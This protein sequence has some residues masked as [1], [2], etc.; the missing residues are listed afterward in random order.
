[1]KRKVIKQGNNT[2][3]ITL[4]KKWTSSIGLKDGDELDIIE[5]GKELSVLFGGDKEGSRAKIDLRGLKSLR[6]M[7]WA[8]SSIHKIG[9]DEIEVIYD[10]PKVLRMIQEEVKSIYIGFAIVEQHSK[11]LVMRSISK[12]SYSEFE[13]ILRRAFL[14]TLSLA[15][16]IL[17]KM[18]NKD[19]ENIKDL[20]SLEKTNNQFTNFCERILIKNGY[21]IPEKTTFKYVIVWNLEKVCDYYRDLCNYIDSQKIKSLPKNL[22]EL[23]KEVNYFFRRFYELIYKFDLQ[24]FDKLCEDETML[25]LDLERYKPKNDYEYKL[26]FIFERIVQTTMD[27]S[28]SLVSLNN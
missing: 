24:S 18:K 10:D 13:Q 20:V 16:S 8:L 17:E 15:D 12:D 3:T 5:K 2:L 6:A 7:R 28:G 14:V 9:F 26:I 19:F 27:F 22:V 23:Y 11:D 1:M 4:P 25:L 21:D